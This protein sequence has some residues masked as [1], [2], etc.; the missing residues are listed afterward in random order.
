V[1][2]DPHPARTDLARLV[3]LVARLR[4]PDGCPWDREQTL[5]DLRAYLL[6]EAHEAAAAIDRRDPQ[7]LADELGDLLFQVAF[8]VR[9]GEESGGPGLGEVLD[10]I[11]SKM[12]DRHPHVF[13]DERL[14]DAHAVRQAW[15][16]RKLR[17]GDHRRESLLDGAAAASMPALLAAYRLTQKAAG[18]GF[19]WPDVGAVLA[20][21]DEEIAEL[22]AEL[23]VEDGRPVTP[24][25]GERRDRLREELGDLLFAAANLARHLELDPEAA[26]AGA[27]L[28]FRRRFAAVEAGLAERG[29]PLGEATLEEMDELWEQAKRA[30][31][32]GRDEI[33]S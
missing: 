30:E 33:T 27:N 21:L 22:R 7:A 29:R 3:D 5:P 19:D 9:L 15:E 23:H 11:E 14:A 32:A 2:S 4:A 6:E 10:R 31:A 13:G 25:A 28:K 16:R 8:L 18:V 26:L 1:T 20:K 12:I 17:A 24:P